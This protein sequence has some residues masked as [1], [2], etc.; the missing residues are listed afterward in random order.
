MMAALRAAQLGSTV[1]LLEK[2]AGLGRKLLL[3]GKG[4]C[5]L[6]NAAGLDVFL[7][8]YGAQGPFLRDAF[9]KFFNTELRHFFEERGVALKV[10]R[11]SRVF[12]VSD[13][14]MSILEA[15]DKE[16][17]ACRVRVCSRTDVRDIVTQDH[18]VTGV[19]LSTGQQLKSRNIILATGGKSYPLTGSTG[20]GILMAARCG[21]RTV[22]LRPAL[23]GLETRQSFPKDLRGLALKNVRVRF[24]NGKNQIVSD[25]GEVLFT[26]FGVSG[27]LVMTH[28]GQV[29]D[30][31]NM[32]RVTASLDLKPSLDEDVLSRRLLKNIRESRRQKVKNALKDYLP[33]RFVDVFLQKS[34]V[35]PDK[36]LCHLSLQ[37]QKSLTRLFKDFILDIKGP[38]SF[39]EAMVTQGG[40]S[41]KEVNPRTME[42]RLVR[43]LFFA[44]EML[45]IDGTTGGFNLQAAFSTGYLAGDSAAAR[46]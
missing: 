41:L 16:L 38:R 34:G 26:D 32:H 14:S 28:S 7:S 19:V 12:P 40:V 24:S 35:S 17:R 46:H 18:A 45:D 36:A 43:G 30:W 39:N 15:L 2:N 21:H 6:T 27:P 42:S 25:I 33:A 10:E 44:G 5:N 9:R 1:V 20:D 23:V 8:S 3:T 4:R 37:E 11:Q 29:V 13:R 31:L 22:P